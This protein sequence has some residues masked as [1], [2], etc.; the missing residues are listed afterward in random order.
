MLETSSFYLLAVLESANHLMSKGDSYKRREKFLLTYPKLTLHP[1]HKRGMIMIIS[2][3]GRSW[4]RGS[5]SLAG[6]SFLGVLRGWNNKHLSF[7]LFEPLFVEHLNFHMSWWCI[8]RRSWSR[9]SSQVI[10]KKM[11]EYAFL[12]GEDALLSS[13]SLQILQILKENFL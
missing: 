8:N 10:N 9:V 12:W 5:S 11:F 13:D 6:P 4:V 7:P 2:I 1:I 3:V